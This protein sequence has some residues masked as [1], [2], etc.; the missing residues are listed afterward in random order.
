LRD[1]HQKEHLT[2]QL[3]VKIK[4]LPEDFIVDEVLNTPLGPQGGFSFFLLE[5]KGHNTVE[6]LQEIARRSRLPFFT[7]SYGGRKDKHALTRQYIAIKKNRKNL[8]FKEKKWSLTPA[9]FL[10]R[11]MGPD[12]IAANRFIVTLR[13]L[14]APDL[15]TVAREHASTLRYGFA[16][17][18]DD[19]RFGTFE[20][21]LG[22]LA[23]KILKKHF[24]GALKIYITRISS[25]DKR[26]ERDR[27]K[28][29]GVHWGDW[30]ACLIQ[31]KTPFERTAFRHLERH[32]HDFIPLLREIPEH[33]LAL[34]FSAFMAF[35][36]NA[37]LGRMMTKKC[38]KLRVHPGI[39]EDYLF[40]DTLQADEE[41]FFKGLLIPTAASK[42]DF[43][44]PEA[45]TIYEQLLEERGLKPS[46]FNITKIRQAYFKSTQRKAVVV[47]GDN[48]LESAEDEIHLGRKKC[49]LKFSLP[50]GSYA[51]MFIKRIF[52]L[53]Y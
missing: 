27:K 41:L 36:W 19:Q 51:T 42:M 22:F 49:V 28:H 14:N 20:A 9:G 46:L 39:I 30:S 43:C 44:G 17:Y 10:N 48:S 6:L 52:S 24:N 47:P 15:D 31:A 38:E 40:Y 4:T 21:S 26:E 2:G 8:A 25:E 34:H 35:L 29:M 37:A 13:D 3:T 45:K 1:P 53:P 12:L 23:E 7:F 11:P 18:F 16:N 33:E 32:P 50:S 5:K